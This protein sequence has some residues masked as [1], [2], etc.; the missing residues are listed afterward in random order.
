MNNLFTYSFLF[1]IIFSVILSCLSFPIAL[2]Y[3]NYGIDE[4]SIYTS[5]YGFTWP[6]PN[7]YK[8][9]SSFGYRNSPT[10]Y[11]SSYHSGIDIPASEN[12]YFLA[13]ISGTISYTGFNG[14]G[15]YTIILEN[16]NIQVIYCHVSPD[17]LVSVRRLCRK[18]TGYRASAVH[19]MSMMFP[20]IH[21]LIVMVC[22]QMVRLLVVIYI[23]L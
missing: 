12:T 3:S 16:D 9:S 14:S 21:M 23:L 20:I 18:S 1:M 11:A 15:G 22:L 8:I 4:S 10:S 17:F 2:D 5:E 13:S 6:I 7:F 19:I